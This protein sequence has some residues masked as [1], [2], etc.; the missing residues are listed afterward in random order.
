MAA[1]DIETFRRDDIW[2]NRIEG[3]AHTLGSG[4]YTQ[5]EAALAGRGAALA[6]QVKHSVRT[7]EGP[8]ADDVNDRHPRDLIG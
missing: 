6:R 7:D 4:F 3:E 2:F 5:E 8:S 1:G